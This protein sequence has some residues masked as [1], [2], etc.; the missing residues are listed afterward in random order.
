MPIG[1]LRTANLSSCANPKIND[2]SQSD[3]AETY[4]RNPPNPRRTNSLS[5][6]Y[7]Q[8]IG[9]KDIPSPPPISNAWYRTQ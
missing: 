5:R 4:L 7:S 8:L 9:S 6:N 1:I 2:R 3:A